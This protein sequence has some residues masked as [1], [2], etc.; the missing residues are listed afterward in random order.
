MSR[1]VSLFVPGR[2]C[3]A[4]EHSDWAASYRT[5]TP[6][7][8]PGA[9]LVVGLRQGI[10][11]TASRTSS[12]LTLSSSLAGPL[13]IERTSL[14]S[15]SRSS[16]PWRFSAAV[17][18][19]I[20]QRYGVTGLSLNVTEESLPAGKGL[21][22]SAAVCVLT[23]RAFNQL[24]DLRLTTAGEMDI[25]YA[26]ERLTGSACGR[27]DQVVAVGPGRVARM[28]FDGELVEHQVLQLREG[29]KIYVV[30]AD[31]GKGKDTRTILA[32]LHR[33]FPER[34]TED[35]KELQ[36]VLGDRNFKLIA[37]MEE[38][39]VKGHASRLGELFI[40][41]QKSFD[42]AAIPFCPDEL[43]SPALHEILADADVQRYTYGG[44]GGKVHRAAS[45]T[46]ACT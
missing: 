37:E 7:I 24:Y 34:A 9:A 25:A 42:E 41:A 38:A 4:G 43:L 46:I 20:R 30:L 18:F 14:T 35:C 36:D 2:L 39:L 12:V 45:Q 32:G 21:S 15:V 29:N 13:S 10:R 6:S 5:E 40:R 3:L 26:A 1:E 19:V 11:A 27:M 23:A 22:S 17:A 16:S 31:L 33:A 28:E 8:S 44:K